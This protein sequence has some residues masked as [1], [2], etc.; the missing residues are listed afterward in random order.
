VFYILITLGLDVTVVI[1]VES[2][3]AIILE[4]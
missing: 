3:L 4:Q 1:A 2:Q